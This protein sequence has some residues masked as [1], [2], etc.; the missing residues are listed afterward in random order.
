MAE[1]KK[2]APCLPDSPL[3][4]HGTIYPLTKRE[5]FAAVIMAGVGTEVLNTQQAAM[6]GVISA[7]ALIRALNLL[8]EELE[9]EAIDHGLATRKCT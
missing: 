1:K 8:D 3:F 2:T 6:W 7:D 9:Q 4:D 5:L